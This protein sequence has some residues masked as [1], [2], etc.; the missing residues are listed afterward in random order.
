MATKAQSCLVRAMG[1]GCKVSAG[2]GT[3]FWSLCDD[4]R[5]LFR[6]SIR[7][8]RLGRLQ[9]F[10]CK[11]PYEGDAPY[12]VSLQTDPQVPVHTLR[13]FCL[14]QYRVQYKYRGMKI[15]FRATWQHHPALLQQPDK[16]D[17]PT[18]QL[19]EQMQPD[20]S[21]RNRK[22]VRELQFLSVL[23]AVRPLLRAGECDRRS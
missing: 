2:S 16:P 17:K 11:L 4:H 7:L 3:M 1:R 10:R 18:E 22:F 5:P 6:Q 12:A 20:G 9:K 8:P 14:R 13:L 19:R 15:R 23:S 21:G